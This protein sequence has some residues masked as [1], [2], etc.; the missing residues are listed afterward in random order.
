MFHGSSGSGQKINFVTVQSH[1]G[2]GWTQDP[3]DPCVGH[4][5]LISGKGSKRWSLFVDCETDNKRAKYKGRTC[6][7]EHTRAYLL[8][9]SIVAVVFGVILTLLAA[10]GG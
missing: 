9:Y 10:A 3:D 6:K 2:N 5:T 1:E 4:K 8:L 7:E